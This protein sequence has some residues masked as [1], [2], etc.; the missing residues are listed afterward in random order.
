MKLFCVPFLLVLSLTDCSGSRVDPENWTCTSLIGPV[1]ESSKGKSPEILE[2]TEP[3]Q[4]GDKTRHEISCYGRAEWS[5]GYG[6]IQYGAHV[7]EGGEVIVEY[8]APNN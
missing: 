2:I 7:S 4:M 8:E 5:Q 1:I 6:N 3:S